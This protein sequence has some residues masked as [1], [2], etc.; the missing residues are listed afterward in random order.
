MPGCSC[1]TGCTPDDLISAHVPLCTGT[2]D[3]LRVQLSD[4]SDSSGE[5]TTSYRTVLLPFAAEV[6]PVVDRQARSMEITPPAGW[7]DIATIQEKRKKN[8]RRRPAVKKPQ[9]IVSVSE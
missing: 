7:L 4:K 6:V 9:K 1:I 5:A 8:V 2:Y 3:T